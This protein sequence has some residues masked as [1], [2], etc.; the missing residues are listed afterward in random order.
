[1]LKFFRRARLPSISERQEDWSFSINQY[2]NLTINRTVIKLCY[3]TD[4]LLSFCLSKHW[5]DVFKENRKRANKSRKYNKKNKNYGLIF[6]GCKRLD[7]ASFPWRQSALMF[8]NKY[9]I[10]YGWIRIIFSLLHHNIKPER[11]RVVIF[12]ALKQ[13]QT[14]KIIEQKFSAGGVVVREWGKSEN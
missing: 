6:L 14:E 1:M 2:V 7:V 5:T 12:F 9:N 13:K 11:P 3:Q 4:F 8:N 10:S